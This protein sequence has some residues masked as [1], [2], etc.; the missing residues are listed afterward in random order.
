MGAADYETPKKSTRDREETRAQIEAWI[1][2]QLPD[3][4][5]VS[6]P[7]IDS[8]S[9]TG[10]SS[11][12]LLFELHLTQAG[13]RQTWPLVARLAPDQADC[14]IF[15]TYDLEGQFRLLSLIAEH[16][17]LPV[18]RMRWLETGT[19][20]IGAPFFVMD[21]V[22]GRVPPDIPP[23]VFAGW[24]F[25]GSAEERR[26][27]QDGTVRAIAALHDID[28]ITSGAS[29]LEFDL[30]GETPLRRHM[31][32]QKSF[33]EWIQQDGVSH[34]AID[35]I[36]TWLEE[37]W[38]A[39]EGETVISWGDSRIG[40]VLYDGWKPAALLDWEMAALGPRELDLGWL[41]FMHRFFHDIATG[42]GQP[43]L[44][45][46]LR[47]EDIATTYE[48]ITGKTPKDL[49]WYFAYAA[50]RHG[51]IMARIH[52]R[53]VQFGEAEWGDD[54]DAVIPHRATIEGILDGTYR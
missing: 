29:F 22:D 36:L 10:M 20:T 50:M 12:T 17:Q 53:M 48:E 19:G 18:P 34:P 14:P 28:P 1:A 31:A 45:D 33:Y 2:K 32:N 38:P 30:P 46:F 39:D 25:E 49:R 5:E 47:L 3:A 43:G 21:R 13:E 27:L 35:A 44:P 7:E 15:P 8:P 41:A 54:P 11:E 51:I 52:R 9:G 23:Y 42:A 4:T 26:T 40:N 6:V 24:L 37:N 16:G